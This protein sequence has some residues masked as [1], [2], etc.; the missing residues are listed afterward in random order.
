MSPFFKELKRRNVV[1][2]A[3]AYTV[4]AWVIAQVADLAADNFDAPGWVMRT[5]LLLLVAGLPLATIFAWAYEL[6]PDGVK[7][8]EDVPV[9]ESITPRTGRKLNYITTAA[10]IVALAFIAWDK[11]G[12]GA[13]PDLIKI[14]DKSVAVL[15]FAD[16]SENQDQEWFADGL[17]EEILN[18]LARLPELQVTAR[19][20]S[21]EF[22]NT[23][24]DISEIADRLGVAHVVEGS[25]RRIGDQLRVTAQL[26]RARDGFHLWS[27][28]YDRDTED[29]FDVQYDVAESIA[30]ALDVVLD[31]DN[32]KRMAAFGTRNVAAFEAFL[33]GRDLYRKAHGRDTENRV[34]LAEAN[35][36]LKRAMVLDP[37]FAL[38]AVLHADRYAHILLEVDSL[39]AGNSDS[40]DRDTAYRLFRQDM[41][42][43]V[44]NAPDAISETVAE[45][46]N[47]F[48]SSSWHRIPGLIARLDELIEAGE[49][50][51]SFITATWLPEILLITGDLDLLERLIARLRES[52]P[53]NQAH[54]EDEAILK[55]ARRDYLGARAIFEYIRRTYGDTAWLRQNMVNLAI[56]SGDTDAAIELLRDDFDFS[57]DFAIA[58]AQLALLQGDHDRALQIALDIE[59]NSAAPVVDLVWIYHELGE[60]PRLNELV[61]R[62]DA[63]PLGPTFIAIDTISNGLFR[64]KRP[65]S[66]DVT[67]NL[68]KRIEEA[69]I[70][71]LYWPPPP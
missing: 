61:S 5:V 1:R 13:T 12:P 14:E 18:S 9:T 64:R 34:T 51:P 2:V 62:T 10:L 41:N 63:L 47:V 23:N 32:R 31:E 22:K 37:N 56:S 49:P 7:K 48:F 25:V 53:L 54:Y 43:A 21:F 70:T 15:P 45:L 29:M 40:L 58:E 17:T 50:P 8:T 33:K 16:L 28:T 60:Q 46:N 65:F 42:F 59:S 24:S 71:D 66:L 27:S 38:P 19:T 68:K 4:V 3:M 26:I 57:G 35:V 36:Y 67:P 6:T 11:L 69:G 39:I 55:W 44:E 20:S 30:S 52:D